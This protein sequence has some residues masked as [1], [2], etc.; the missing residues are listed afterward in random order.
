MVQSAKL[1]G[2]IPRRVTRGGTGDPIRAEIVKIRHLKHG[3]C[4]YRIEEYDTGK[5]LPCLFFEKKKLSSIVG[6]LSTMQS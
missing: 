6:G 3:V 4:I 1:R 2:N 5:L